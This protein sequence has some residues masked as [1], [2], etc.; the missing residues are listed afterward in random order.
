MIKNIY[1]RFNFSKNYKKE[2]IKFVKNMVN[3]EM[4]GNRIYDG[5]NNHYQQ[6]PTE[7]V[8]LI[9]ELK[10]LS[11]K[12]NF[13]RY[14]EIGYSSGINLNFLNKFFKFE[15]LVSV[16][17]LGSG[18]NT[19]TFYAN[20]RFKNLILIC[21]DSTNKKTIDNVKNN[22]PYDIVFIDGDHKYKTVE[23]D[24]INYSKLL[25]KDGVIIFHDVKFSDTKDEHDRGV[26]AFWE[27]LKRKEKKKFT[28]KEFYDPY[29]F[30]KTGI[31]ILIK[32]K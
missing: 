23:K 26:P 6:N 25:S 16:D 19:N 28:I 14:L 15:K 10:K 20:L 30:T 5:I 1:T 29:P 2:L 11:K 3:V 24:Y 12:R 21:G 7:I 9:F 17:I 22:G 13:K 31:G 32:K 27:Y 18:I 4:G 8:D